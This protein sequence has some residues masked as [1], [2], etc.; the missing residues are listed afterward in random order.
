MYV[1]T[2]WLV[3]HGVY[4][5]SCVSWCYVSFSGG[6]FHLKVGGGWAGHLTCTE[7]IGLMLWCFYSTDFEYVTR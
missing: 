1:C 3:C 2:C 5:L 4:M 6:N 7:R